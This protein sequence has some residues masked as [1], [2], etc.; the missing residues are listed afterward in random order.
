MYWVVLGG[1]VGDFGVCDV[2]VIVVC[3]VVWFIVEDEW[4]ILVLVLLGD[5]VLVVVWD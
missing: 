2:E 5:G 1:W 3:E 4:F